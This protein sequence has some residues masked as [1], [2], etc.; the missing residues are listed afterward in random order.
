MFMKKLFGGTKSNSAAVTAVNDAYKRRDRAAITAAV[1]S[2]IGRPE[3]HDVFR[4]AI[5]RT[6][7]ATI[8]FNGV[9]HRGLLM[10]VPVVFTANQDAEFTLGD[11]D[12]SVCKRIFEDSLTEGDATVLPFIFSGSVLEFTDWSHPREVVNM[13]LN[14]VAG[15]T[16]DSY[17]RDYMIDEQRDRI[18]VPALGRSYMTGAIGVIFSSSEEGVYPAGKM[19]A[20]HFDAL[21]RMMAFHLPNDYSI[22]VG[23]CIVG[24]WALEPNCKVQWLLNILNHLRDIYGK[25]YSTVSMTPSRD[26]WLVELSRAGGQQKPV[27][28]TEITTEA[29]L[30]NQYFAELLHSNLLQMQFAPSFQCVHQ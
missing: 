25:E 6:E 12:P 5:G 13:V 8:R 20:S 29:T 18:D 19:D 17:L 4:A 30:G 27:F 2:S 14:T 24:G 15:D 28:V 7:S 21:G 10:Y 26:G 1:A 16:N 11:I 3:L 23:R 22:H 9:T